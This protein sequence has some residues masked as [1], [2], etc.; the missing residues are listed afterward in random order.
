MEMSIGSP[1]RGFLRC[2]MISKRALRRELKCTEVLFKNL[3]NRGLLS[4]VD[5]GEDIF[6]SLQEGVDYVECREC[7]SRGHMLSGKHLKMCSSISVQE[8][9]D[10]HPKAP[11]ISE[12]AKACKAKTEEQKRAQSKKLRE[13]FKTPEGEKTRLQIS[14]ASKRMQAGPY[15]KV[16][17]EN[18]KAWKRENGHIVSKIT[19]ERWEEGGD[20]RIAVER[21][22]RENREESLDNL[23]KARQNIN[24][25]SKPHLRLKEAMVEAGIEGFHT[26]YSLG[27]YRIDEA[28]PEIQ[29]AVEVD[30]CYWHGC[31]V[32]GF[33]ATSHNSRVDKAKNTFLKKRGWKVLRI[34]E[35]EIKEELGQ[36]V[37]QIKRTVESCYDT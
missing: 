35:H 27:W 34:P 28:N 10:R 17:V 5:R 9:L 24:V 32:C 3:V 2:V 33:K 21:W 29:V 7:G 13:R 20:L 26:E 4:V 11:V 1:W 36:C 6:E 12:T 19:K 16:A 15:G 14:Q 23:A 37:A 30:G 25:T 8:Y 18:L 31:S 22:H